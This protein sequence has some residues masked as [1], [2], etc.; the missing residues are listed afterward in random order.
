M[1]SKE[2]RAERIAA[3][4]VLDEEIRRTGDVPAGY[5]VRHSR[6]TDTLHFGP[7]PDLVALTKWCCDHP[8]VTATAVPLYLTVDW[9]RGVSPR[10]RDPLSAETGPSL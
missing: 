2:R 10:R 3:A 7:F 4:L 8:E 6:A 5:M 1:V 9:N